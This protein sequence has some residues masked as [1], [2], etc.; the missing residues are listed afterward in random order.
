MQEQ[1]H[2]VSRQAENTKIL[3]KN[4]KEITK[5]SNTVTEMKIASDGFLKRLDTAKKESVRLKRCP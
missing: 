4:Q 1:V 5:I 2:N 3:R